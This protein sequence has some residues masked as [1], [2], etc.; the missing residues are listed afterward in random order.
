[1]V[2]PAAK[3]KLLR[4][5]VLAVGCWS[6]SVRFPIAKLSGR[7]DSYHP[8]TGAAAAKST[9]MCGI[10]AKATKLATAAEASKPLSPRRTLG[11]LPRADLVQPPGISRPKM[12][13][14]PTY[15]SMLMPNIT[16]ASA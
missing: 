15:S 3:P 5:E 13:R 11:S 14:P 4:M 1:M 2:A 7:M 10:A 12:R 9:P 6:A 8:P 16:E